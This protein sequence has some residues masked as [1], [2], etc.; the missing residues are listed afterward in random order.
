MNK[1]R[2]I[3]ISATTGSSIGLD[4]SFTSKIVLDLLVM[5]P[6]NHLVDHEHS[7]VA[8]IATVTREM[9]ENLRIHFRG[10]SV[11]PWGHQ[12]LEKNHDHLRAT[13]TWRK[14]TII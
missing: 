3:L 11:P 10:P 9:V 8:Y 12:H 7:T 4:L 5:I 13:N 2:K 6:W 1:R 14:T